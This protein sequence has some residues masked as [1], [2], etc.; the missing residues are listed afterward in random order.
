MATDHFQAFTHFL[1]ARFTKSLSALIALA[2]GKQICLAYYP[3]IAR[4][5]DAC[6]DTGSDWWHGMHEGLST[7]NYSLLRLGCTYW[8]PR[9][10]AT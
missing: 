6:M 9:A 7:C 3:S 1:A 8:I 10:G 4:H 5:S 2:A